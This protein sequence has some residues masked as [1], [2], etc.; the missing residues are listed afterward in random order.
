[1]RRGGA[2]GLSCGPRPGRP[3]SAA[4]NSVGWASGR[5]SRPRAKVRRPRPSSPGALVEPGA[6][7]HAEDAAEAKPACRPSCAAVDRRCAAVPPMSR[8]HSPRQRPPQVKAEQAR[9]PDPGARARVRGFGIGRGSGCLCGEAGQTSVSIPRL[10]AELRRPTPHCRTAGW[11]GFQVRRV[12]F[13][14]RPTVETLSRRPLNYI[15]VTHK[16]AP[17]PFWPMIQIGPLLHSGCRAWSIAGM[18]V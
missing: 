10:A 14:F 3:P 17:Q 13:H 9:W 7:G 16:P 6:R 15:E 11:E 1:M 4:T 5:G 2:R 8:L 12:T 18:P